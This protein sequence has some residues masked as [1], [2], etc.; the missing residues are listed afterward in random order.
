MIR[1][2]LSVRL[3]LIFLSMKNFFARVLIVTLACLAQIQVSGCNSALSG[4]N[5][6]DMSVD[7]SIDPNAPD[8]SL[9]GDGGVVIRTDAGTSVCYP[10]TC[11]GKLY[12]CGNCLDDD[13]D[14]LFD[15][16][17]PDCLGPCDNTE[18]G[19]TLGIPG[20][21]NAPCKQD[22]FFDQDTG[23]GNDDCYWDHRCDANEVA[24]N[25]YPE[26]SA[27]K[28]DATTKLGGGLSCTAAAAVGGQSATCQSVCGPL[29]PNGCDCFGCCAIGPQATQTTGIWLGSTD[30]AG[31]PSCTLDQLGDPAKCHPCQITPVCFKP[32]G[33]CQLC[34]GKSTLPADCYPSGGGGSGCPATLCPNRQAC[35]VAGCA[36]CPA[37][38]Y[39]LTGCCT[40]VVG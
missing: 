33:R 24:P 12:Q 11:Q 17:D 39:C 22:C 3:L 7:M 27:C 16:Q 26:G 6:P 14:G 21:N 37:G 20:A 30:A 2:Q 28:Y 1:R 18:T 4:G 25:Y 13:N 8:L 5:E 40:A 34:I 32:C 35:G 31:N 23:S 36:A 29:T 9:A 19:L 38:Q 15:S 10:A